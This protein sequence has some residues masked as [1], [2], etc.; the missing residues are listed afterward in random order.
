MQARFVEPGEE[1]EVVD[2]RSHF[3]SFRGIV[4]RRVGPEVY[5]R[6]HGQHHVSSKLFLD[7]QLTRT[8]GASA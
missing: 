8:R 2:Y 1:V 6:F 5:V 3:Y 4:D 7:N